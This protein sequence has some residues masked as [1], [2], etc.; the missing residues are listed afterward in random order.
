[1]IRS[2]RA[3][4]VIAAGILTGS[5]FAVAPSTV[6]QASG[7]A[8]PKLGATTLTVSQPTF[9]PAGTGARAIEVCTGKVRSFDGTPLR[10]DVTLPTVSYVKPGTTTPAKSPLVMMLSGYSNDVC[11]FESKSFAGTAVSG[12]TDAIGTPGFD[13]NNAWFA[14]HGYVVLTYT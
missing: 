12:C 3:F 6:G 5:L 9:T 7:P 1:M 2:Q 11:Q 14:S 10:V 8:C 4:Q 13:W